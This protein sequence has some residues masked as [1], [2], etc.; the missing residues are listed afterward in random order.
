MSF[1]VVSSRSVCPTTPSLVVIPV[2][3]VR[4][5]HCASHKVPA[6]RHDT[7][8][9]FPSRV[10]HVQMSRIYVHYHV[11][12]NTSSA[13]NVHVHISANVGEAMVH[14]FDTMKRVHVKPHQL[15]PYPVHIPDDVS[16]HPAPVLHGDIQARRSGR[17]S[18]VMGDPSAQRRLMEHVGMDDEALISPISAGIT[19]QPVVRHHLIF[20]PSSLLLLPVALVARPHLER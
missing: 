7:Q 10:C 15:A 13:G 14:D 12:R 3:L 18:A 16:R 2:A 20:T 4:H 19:R 11:P 9:S 1:V 17:C 8:Y 5:T 6:V